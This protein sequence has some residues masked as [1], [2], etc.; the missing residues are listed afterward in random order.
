MI[1]LILLFA[2]SLV[3][4]ISSAHATN[5]CIREINARLDLLEQ[6]RARKEQDA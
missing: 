6:E 4:A 3:L 1:A 2:F 5:Q